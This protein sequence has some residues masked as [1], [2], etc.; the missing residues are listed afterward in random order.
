MV[1]QPP[2]AH[3]F[4]WAINNYIT[5]G[6]WA[7]N[8]QPS[9]KTKGDFTA[10]FAN[11]L[12]IFIAVCSFQSWLKRVQT[13]LVRSQLLLNFLPNQAWATDSGIKLPVWLG[14]TEGSRTIDSWIN[15]L[16][17]AGAR[18]AKMAVNALFD[19][20]LKNHRLRVRICR[21]VGVK[22]DVCVGGGNRAAKLAA[23]HQ[24]LVWKKT[25]RTTGSWF[26]LS[27]ELA[28]TDSWFQDH[29]MPVR[30][31]KPPIMQSTCT[32]INNVTINLREIDRWR[33][34]TWSSVYLE[35]I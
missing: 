21:V 35:V 5:C 12:D 34:S 25:P 18:A 14:L 28:A 7:R 15:L 31:P 24:G 16:Q 29:K 6:L 22:L 27:A 10:K 33:S 19:K 1:M 11:L 17:V 23:S 20:R 2:V 3:T 30:Q 32:Y 8:A 9:S 26:K 4:W 13:S